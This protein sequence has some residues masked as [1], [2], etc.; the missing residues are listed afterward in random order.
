MKHAGSIFLTACFSD[1]VPPFGCQMLRMAFVRLMFVLVTG[2]AVITA[3][4]I[5][6]AELWKQTVA[7][8]DGKLAYGKDAALQ[9]GELR[10]SKA[11]GPHPVVILVHG[12]CFVDQFPRGIRATRRLSRSV[13]W[14]RH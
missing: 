2:C 7:Q 1:Y 10:L 6:P 5:Q 13:H 11:K 3:Q 8:A 4:G 14:P 9:F 12:G